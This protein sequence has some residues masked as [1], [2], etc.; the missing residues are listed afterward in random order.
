MK[1]SIV[2]MCLLGVIGSASFA[3]AQTDSTKFFLE[4]ESEVIPEFDNNNVVMGVGPNSLFYL[5]IYAKN[6]TGLIGYK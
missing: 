3:V 6:V 2:M 1:K 4:I 5:S